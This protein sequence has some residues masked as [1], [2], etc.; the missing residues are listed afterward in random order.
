MLIRQFLLI[1]YSLWRTPLII[2]QRPIYLLACESEVIIL[3]HLSIVNQGLF[4]GDQ[5][6]YLDENGHP[7]DILQNQPY[8]QYPT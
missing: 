8:E 6:G 1:G 7:S 4:S 5:Q 3:S 2:S